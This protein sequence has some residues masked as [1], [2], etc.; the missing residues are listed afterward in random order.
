MKVK[1]AQLCPTL[2]EPVDYTVHGILQA[3]TL[4]WVAFPFFRGSSQPRDQTQVSCIG[5]DSL[6]AEPPWQPGVFLR[7]GDQDRK[8]DGCVRTQEDAH[9][10]AQERGLS[11]NQPCSHCD[12][13]LPASSTW[14]RQACLDL[15]CV[16]APSAC[17]LCDGS[18]SS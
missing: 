15:R 8:E 13:E 4:E 11:R 1:V 17:S 9:L 3:R 6:A 12:L 16:S 18:A 10:W 14:R 5:G 2:C 7:R